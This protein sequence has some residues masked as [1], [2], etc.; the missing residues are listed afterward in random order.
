MDTLYFFIRK[1]IV[2]SGRGF[3]AALNRILGCTTKK[4]LKDCNFKTGNRHYDSVSGFKPRENFLEG[5]LAGLG[6]G[7]CK[8]VSWWRLHSSSVSVPSC[9]PVVWRRTSGDIS[10]IVPGVLHVSI[11]VWSVSLTTSC[12]LGRLG[13]SWALSRIGFSSSDFHFLMCK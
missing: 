3:F 12:D 4:L 10:G 6:L 7:R 2:A 8:Q 5:Q 9:I 1:K 13:S 11:F